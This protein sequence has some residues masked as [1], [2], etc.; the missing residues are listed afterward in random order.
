MEESIGRHR[1]ETV[2]DLRDLANKANQKLA[3][4]RVRL[5]AAMPKGMTDL[6]MRVLLKMCEER[7]KQISE[8][9]LLKAI[10]PGVGEIS[11]NVLFA[12]YLND[13]EACKTFIE[14]NEKMKLEKLSFV[15]ED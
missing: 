10:L 5:I 14:S 15:L 11:M 4:K 9:V 8:V 6:A 1:L 13:D 7:I 2:Q 12:E 3:G